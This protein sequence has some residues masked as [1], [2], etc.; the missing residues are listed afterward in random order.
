MQLKN[1]VLGLK[2]TSG[3]EFSLKEVANDKANTQ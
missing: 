2:V 1:T 3:Y